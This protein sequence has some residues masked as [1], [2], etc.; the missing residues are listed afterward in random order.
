MAESF[1]EIVARIKRTD[2]DTR[3][4]YCKWYDLFF[5]KYRYTAKNIL[6]IGVCVYA[7][8]CV[9][10]LAEYFPNATIWAVDIDNTRCCKEVF[11]HPRIKFLHESAYEPKLLRHFSDIKFDVIIDDASHEQKDQLKFLDMILPYLKE[12]GTHIIEDCVEW[13]WRPYIKQLWDKGLQHTLI[14]E[15]RPDTYDNVLIKLER[16]K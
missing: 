12:D 4:G 16:V 5:E 10:S 14:D 13:H 11:D 3:H 6:E 2:K 15:T 8:G 1:K 7:G 9:L